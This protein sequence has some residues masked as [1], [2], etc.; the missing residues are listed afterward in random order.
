MNILKVRMNLTTMKNNRNTNKSPMRT[1][2]W[3]TKYL[4][5][6]SKIKNK[7]NN[8]LT[9]NKTKL[10]TN[11][12]RKNRKC[13]RKCKNLKKAK[14]IKMKMMDGILYLLPK[15]PKEKKLMMIWMTMKA[16]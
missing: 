4:K 6:I 1:I 13:K 11:R 5:K 9:K 12:N 3:K 15:N 10:K 16:G 2:N 14:R 8:M 7:L